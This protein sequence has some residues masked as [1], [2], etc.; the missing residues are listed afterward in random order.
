MPLRTTAQ[1]ALLLIGL[2]VWGYG[3]RVNDQRL[4]WI[5]IGFFAAAVILRLLRA[6]ID[7]RVIGALPRF[8]RA[9]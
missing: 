3:A 9:G 2:V 1:L 4:T 8:A 7:R 6:R 5:G